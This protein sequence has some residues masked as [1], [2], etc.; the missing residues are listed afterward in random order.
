MIG[1][2]PDRV[3]QYGRKQCR[4][5]VRDS[6]RFPAEKMPARWREAVDAWTQ[7]D[8]VQVNLEDAPLRQRQ[9]DEDRE[10]GLQPFA[11]V[12]A[13]A[14]QV[15]VLRNLLRDRRRAAQWSA[16]GK[17]LYGVADRIDV[18]AEVIGE[19]LVL[20]GYYRQRRRQP[21][22]APVR[23]FVSNGD[24]AAVVCQHER[25][26][27]RINPAQWLHQRDA[28]AK[29]D[30]RAHDPDAQHAVDRRAT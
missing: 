22:R 20:G 11:Q 24:T 8:D 23:S 15:Q 6:Q 12:A 14:Q 17:I 7:L 9:V 18:E 1:L 27:R 5:R 3:R 19:I 21:D 16:I 29:H 10:P 30:N 4:F 28:H 2:Q 13:A 26:D 25:R